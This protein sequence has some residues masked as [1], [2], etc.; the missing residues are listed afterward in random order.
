MNSLIKS[1]LLL[2]GSLL[3]TQALAQVTF[4][5]RENFSGR[6]F[7][8]QRPQVVNFERLGFNDRASSV[9]VLSERWQVCDD[10]RFG[11]RC[12]VLSPGRYR[13]LASMGLNDRV[14]SVR[15]IGR[16]ERIDDDLVMVP[17]DPV[18]DNR[19][20]NN[21]RLYDAE[22]IAVRAVVGPPERRCWIE[23][24]QVVEEE[25]SRANVPGAL[26]GA[27]IGGIIGHQIGNGGGRDIATVGGVV[28]GAAIG[29]NV[30]RSTDGQ[31]TVGRD[32]QRCEE[33]VRQTQPDYWDVTYRFR[34]IEHQVQMTSPPGRTLSVNRRGEPRS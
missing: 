23:R 17:P 4:Y 32:V 9:I 19:R 26:A 34:G 8:P 15:R 16:N 29:A 18:Y 20:R 13:S 27:L 6:S 5:E 22:V 2:A 14:S 7:S 24:E 1:A 28:G 11:G 25:Q 3:A 30:G 33:N 12:A 21:E 31:R 10:V